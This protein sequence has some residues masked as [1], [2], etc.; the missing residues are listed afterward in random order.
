M[1]T[2]E[3]RAAAVPLTRQRRS[4]RH[5]DLVR[6]DGHVR[7]RSDAVDAAGTTR[8]ERLRAHAALVTLWAGLTVT[9]LAYAIARGS[10]GAVFLA[11]SVASVTRLA[12]TALRRSAQRDHA[13]PTRRVSFIP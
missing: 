9:I 2:T 11:V 8:R 10:V 3:V 5:T 7:D 1:T 13:Q 12:W 6:H 4:K